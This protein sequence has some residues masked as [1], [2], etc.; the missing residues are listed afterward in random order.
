M[1]SLA[2]AACTLR[3]IIAYTHRQIERA[4]EIYKH[5]AEAG[6]VTRFRGKEQHCTDCIRVTIGTAEENKKFLALLQETAK[7]F[8]LR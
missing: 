1:C 3:L 7:L 8:G 6:V 4:V 2:S 5:M